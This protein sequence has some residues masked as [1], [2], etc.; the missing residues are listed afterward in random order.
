MFQISNIRSALIIFC[1]LNSTFGEAQVIKGRI[2]S[3]SGEPVPYATVYIQQLRQ[4][5][6]ANAKG[7]Y[8]IRLTPGSYLITYQS[9][10]YS[11]VVYETTVTDQLIEK[12]VT[13]PLQ[14][15]Q[16]PEV[17]ITATGEDPAYGIMRKTIGMAP[18]YLNNISHYKAEV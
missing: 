14:Y 16:V 6:T 13:L 2:S 10:G 17:R 8:E 5:T 15:Y 12:D 1:I 4:G 3:Q 7:D 11:P 9:L 18:Y